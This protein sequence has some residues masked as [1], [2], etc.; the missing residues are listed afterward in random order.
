MHVKC[1]RFYAVIMLFATLASLGACR[2]EPEGY[3]VV[4]Y[5]ASTSEWTIIR[6]GVFDGKFLKKR[7]VVVCEFY[8]QA[9]AEHAVLG[10]T[11]CHLQVGRLMV[12]N[13]TG[14]GEQHL[15]ISELPN[16]ALI[17]VQGEGLNEVTQSFSIHKYEVVE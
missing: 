5:D 4:A 12:P 1:T 10:R 14:K 8:R 17:I 6:T 7:M 3:R 15:D 13:P 16:E 9:A 11:A 2:S